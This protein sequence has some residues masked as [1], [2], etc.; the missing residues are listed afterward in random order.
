LFLGITPESFSRALNILENEG[1]KIE[2]KQVKQTDENPLCLYC[3]KVVGTK[4]KYYK[5]S[6]CSLI[7]YS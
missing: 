3:D 5:T 2:N 7:F 6:I 1:I 4:C